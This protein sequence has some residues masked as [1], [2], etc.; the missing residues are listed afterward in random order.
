VFF[1]HGGLIEEQEGLRG[2]LAR[3]SFWALNG[4]YPVYFV[5]ETGL[6]ESV[7][8]IIGLPTRAR[9]RGAVADA[10]IEAAARAGGKAVWGQMKKSAE[11]SAAPGGGSRL[12]AD[13]AAE[14]SASLAGA[15]EFHALGHSAGAIFHAHFLPLL[16]QP[17]AG[18]AALS[19]RTLHLLAPAIT[20]DLF[21]DTLKPLVGAGKPITSL[22]TYTMTD[23]LEQQDHTVKPYGK[24]LLYLVSGSFEDTVPTKLLGMQ[25]GLKQDAPLIGFFGLAGTEKVADICFSRTDP[26]A[27]R[28]ARTESSSHGGFDNDVATM[29]SVVRRVLDAADGSAVVDYFEDVVPGFERSAVGLPAQDDRPTATVTRAR[30]AT[31]ARKQARKATRKPA[32]KR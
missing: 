17:R 11:K 16:V 18:G 8:D 9:D 7:R 25:K 4:I 20:I 5:W 2:V 28:N 26:A 22:T 31:P 19:V 13:L 32:R 27:P 21:K 15:I 12:T 29:T 1:A 23:D 24:S 30:T 3:R 10:A 6:F 14:L